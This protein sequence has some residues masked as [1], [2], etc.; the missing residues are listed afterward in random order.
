VVYFLD[1]NSQVSWS[2]ILCSVLGLLTLCPVPGSLQWSSGLCLLPFG[3]FSDGTDLALWVS[4]HRVHLSGSDFSICLQIPSPISL[5]IAFAFF[6]QSTPCPCIHTYQQLLLSLWDSVVIKS[7]VPLGLTSLAVLQGVWHESTFSVRCVHE[8]SFQV[9]VNKPPSSSLLMFF[10]EWCNCWWV[11]DIKVI[12]YYW[13]GV[14][15]WFCVQ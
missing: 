15:L 10:S 5:P 6:G 13:V 9:N 12:H 3:R 4:C 7:M 14:Y 11:L 1:Q 2:E 8:E